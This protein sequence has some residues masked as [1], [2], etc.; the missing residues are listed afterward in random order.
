MESLSMTKYI[1]KLNQ[2]C[3]YLLF[4]HWSQDIDTV[5]KVHPPLRYLTSSATTATGTSK[6]T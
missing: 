6:I 2:K 3:T 1:T 4:C 5:L